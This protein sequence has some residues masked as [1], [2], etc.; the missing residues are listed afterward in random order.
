M[1]FYSFSLDICVI[2]DYLFENKIKRY[3]HLK[4][5]IYC[6]NYSNILLISKSY[7]VQNI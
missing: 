2:K 6:F 1:P 3:T 5:I 7:E 4:P